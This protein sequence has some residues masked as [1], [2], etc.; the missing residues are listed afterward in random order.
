VH[1]RSAGAETRISNTQTIFDSN[2]PPFFTP[3]VSDGGEREEEKASKSLWEP[4]KQQVLRECKAQLRSPKKGGKKEKKKRGERGK[5]PSSV[6]SPILTTSRRSGMEGRKRK[7]QRKGGCHK[8]KG[9]KGGNKRRVYNGGKPRSVV[10]PHFTPH[11]VLCGDPA[12]SIIEEE[13]ARRKGTLNARKGKKGRDGTASL[14]R[15][16]DIVCSRR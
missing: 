10:L 13:R 11:S 2:D 15:T 3:D 12:V 8:R 7:S 6:I 9:K 14:S 4:P 5:T 16:P 1:K